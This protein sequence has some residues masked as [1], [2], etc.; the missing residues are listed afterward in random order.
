MLK[1]EKSDHHRLR[2]S[3]AA[4]DARPAEGSGDQREG[5]QGREK[6]SRGQGAQ[7]PQPRREIVMQIA[8]V[9]VLEQEL[10]GKVTSLM[11]ANSCENCCGMLR[12]LKDSL[13]RFKKHLEG[14][15]CEL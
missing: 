14:E 1:T 5:L 9:E 12:K 4:G 8:R 2:Q 6:L 3:K 10:L 13:I 15:A 7:H 11:P